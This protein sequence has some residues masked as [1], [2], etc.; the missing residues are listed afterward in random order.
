M[1]H[2]TGTPKHP[3]SGRKK[4]TRNK[5]TLDGEA[6]ARAI[7]DDPAVRATFLQQ[8]RDGVMPA[9]LI[10]TLLSYAFGK[11]IDVVDVEGTGSQT[12]TIQIT[13]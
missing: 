9:E 4:G 6:Y 11:P 13:F 2:V 8:A 3:A 1:A 12:R 7:I 5:R 10:K